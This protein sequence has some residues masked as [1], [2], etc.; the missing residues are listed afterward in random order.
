MI[1][2]FHFSHKMCFY[3]TKSAV[4][5]NKDLV[6]VISCIFADEPVKKL[7]S[8]R[9]KAKAGIEPLRLGCDG[10][11]IHSAPQANFVEFS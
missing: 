4:V 5:L 9:R 8:K 1:F 7:I 11:P 10:L 3:K 2:M 6:C